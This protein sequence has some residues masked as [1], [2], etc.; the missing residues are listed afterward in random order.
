ML[1]LLVASRST[2]LMDSPKCDGAEVPQT[3]NGTGRHASYTSDDS[4]VCGSDVEKRDL[5]SNSVRHIDRSFS[6]YLGLSSPVSANL[7]DIE[8]DLADSDDEET[9]DVSALDYQ[10]SALLA[11]S[12]RHATNTDACA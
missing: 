7:D 2:R 3:P 6:H 11:E 1:V 8:E 12:H 5:E 9:P 4:T 10:R